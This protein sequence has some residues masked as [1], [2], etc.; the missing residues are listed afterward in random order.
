M[1]ALAFPA[2]HATQ[3]LAISEF[4]VYL[5]CISHG[6]V[7]FYFAL[8]QSF[9]GNDT[10]ERARTIVHTRPNPR[11]FSASVT[12]YQ[13]FNIH[14]HPILG[15]GAYRFNTFIHQQLPF[16][17]LRLFLVPICSGVDG[18]FSLLFGLRVGGA[19]MPG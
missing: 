6:L 8:A 16:R 7:F 3:Q 19:G 13:Y 12:L 15:T 17:G 1:P 11:T 2:R 9:G 18:A 14:I 10:S 5:G 4:L